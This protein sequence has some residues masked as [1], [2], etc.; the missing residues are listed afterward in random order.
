MV[1]PPREGGGGT[2][3]PA[4]MYAARVLVLSYTW[5]YLNMVVLWCGAV[6]FL[7]ESLE[8]LESFFF[9]KKLPQ[10]PG[11]VSGPLLNQKR[12]ILKRKTKN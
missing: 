2:R 12:N 11:R 6:L 3:A 8:S 1:P 4:L 7:T 10:T 5:S 9:K